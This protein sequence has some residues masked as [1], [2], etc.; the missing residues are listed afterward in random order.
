MQI[1]ITNGGPHPADK[2]ADVTTAAILDLVRIADDADTPEAAAARQAKRELSPVLFKILNDAHSKVQHHERGELAKEGL[3][4][5]AAS[6]NTAD[7]EHAPGVMKQ[8]KAALAATPFA[9]HFAKPEVITIVRRIVGQHIANNMHIERKWH[10][11]R[12]EAANA[13]A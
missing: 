11:D 7:T 8:I 2:W 5:C 1:M 13:G 3:A 4:R 6:L 12:A 10:A 9:D